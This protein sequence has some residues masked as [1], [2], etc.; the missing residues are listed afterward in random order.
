MHG[1]PQDARRGLA[2]PGAHQHILRGAQQP[3]SS[4]AKPAIH[5]A[6][7]RLLKKKLESH[8]YSASLFVMFYNF[9]RIH[10]MLR[11]TPAMEAGVTAK[12]W[13]VED[14]VAPVEADEVK[15]IPGKRGPYKKLAP[16]RS[17]P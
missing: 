3:H 14:I 13:Y 10:K 11:V 2:R 7:K 12:L 16:D 5:Q 9:C 1:H 8:V 6:Y 17:R 15:V 4:D